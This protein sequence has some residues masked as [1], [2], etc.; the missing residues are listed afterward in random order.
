MPESIRV[1]HS[2]ECRN[3]SGSVIPANAGIQSKKRFLIVK[4]WFVHWIPA[5]AGMTTRQLHWNDDETAS[6]E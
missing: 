1:R 4:G 5:F 6:L 2:G 3:P